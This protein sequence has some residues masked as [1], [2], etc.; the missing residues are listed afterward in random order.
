MSYSVSCIKRTFVSQENRKSLQFIFAQG[1]RELSQLGSATDVENANAKLR[2]I[3]FKAVTALNRLRDDSARIGTPVDTA[4][5]RKRVAA[6][7]Q[8]LRELAVDFKQAAE[9]HPGKESTAAQKIIRDFQ[10][11]LRSSERLMSSSREKEAASL[12]RFAPKRPQVDTDRQPLLPEVDPQQNLKQQQLVQIEGEL[13]FNEAIIAERDAAIVEINT[14]IGE[15]GQIFQ[16]LAVLIND[17]GEMLDDIEANISRAGNRVGDA[18]V[19]LVR[20]ERSQRRARTGWC[21]L[22]LLAL[23]VLGVLLLIL[24]A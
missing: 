6:S 5:L 20:A 17:Q 19:Q 16:D 8:R 1:G 14:Q 3:Q 22:F 15:V 2:S 11:L 21:F 24:M 9:H 7:G 4:D 12:P 13:K 23:G 10:G 18:R